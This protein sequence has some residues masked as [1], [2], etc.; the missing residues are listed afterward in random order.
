MLCRHTT[1]ATS[2]C[3][4]KITF[5]FPP[6]HCL[7][8]PSQPCAMSRTHRRGCQSAT[9]EPSRPRT[10]KHPSPPPLP[11]SAAAA[12]SA[13]KT[14]ARTPPKV[15]PLFA[16]L[17][18]FAASSASFPISAAADQL[19]RIPVQ[20][21]D[22]DEAIESD[23]WSLG[24]M[25]G[26]SKESIASK[27][28][29]DVPGVAQA[30]RA[31]GDFMDDA[32][33]IKNCLVREAEEWPSKLTGFAALREWPAADKS[34]ISSTKGRP[35]ETRKYS[36]SELLSIVRDTNRGMD[37]I[38]DQL[39]KET[40]GNFSKPT[41]PQAWVHSEGKY[42]RCVVEKGFGVRY[43]APG[44]TRKQW[45]FIAGITNDIASV[46][47]QEWER[48]YITEYV[49]VN[50]AGK[51]ITSLPVVV[52]PFAGA[53]NED[54][55]SVNTSREVHTTVYERWSGPV[56]LSSLY[57]MR[58]TD[59]PA[60]SVALEKADTDADQAIDA[61]TPSNI[62]ILALPM[63]LSII[64]LSLISDVGTF[65]LLMYTL[66]TD[67]LTTIP[68]IIKGFELL[69]SGTRS[70]IADVTQFA[71]TKDGPWVV[72]ETWVAECSLQG[73]RTT[74]IIF[75]AV[76]FLFLAVGLIAEWQAR[77]LRQRW[78]E[79]GSLDKSMREHLK[80]SLLQHEFRQKHGLSPRQPSNAA[81]VDE[82][83]EFLINQSPPPPVASVA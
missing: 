80:A 5:V 32:I 23:T 18:A 57:D 29:A 82:E 9:G 58:I 48:Q 51:F 36:P 77:A 75:I 73:V 50:G 71:G 65:G 62:A 3:S 1:P 17:L 44:A 52:R 76:G 22:I 27:L 37:A 69:R 67:V 63:V 40:A 46:F 26:I 30:Y 81:V 78:A 56:G 55:F 47:F 15:T 60:L 13:V 74:G 4:V 16:V 39:A 59:V 8:F 24:R 79:N 72:A 7:Q 34:C 14:L 25:V 2:P 41:A 42:K 10:A 35:P 54:S 53:G 28:L 12:H 6:F 45:Y 83:H 11:P 20:Q 61:T 68:F 64:P 21:S 31:L 70:H 19:T 33:E 38:K 66:L 49:G 43:H